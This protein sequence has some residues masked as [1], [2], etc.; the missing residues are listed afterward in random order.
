MSSLRNLAIAGIFMAGCAGPQ[1]AVRPAQRVEP[2][3]GR[4]V[5][6]ATQTCPRQRSSRI[7]ECMFEGIAQTC[8]ERSGTN[9]DAYYACVGEGLRQPVTPEPVQLSITVGQG[10]EVFSFRTGGPAIYQFAK[11]DVVA[12]DSTGVDFNFVV[13]RV[14]T[15]APTEPMVLDQTQV[16]MNFDGTRTGQWM[17]LDFTELWNFRAES[18]GDGRARVSFQTD[19]PAIVVRTSGGAQPAAEKK[20]PAPKA[21]QAPAV[22]PPAE[23][24]S[25]T[26]TSPD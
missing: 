6:L 25:T 17:H 7:Q 24:R 2:P 16:R 12:V 8:R 26:I 19:N 21:Q 20:P 5:E 13:S 14:E 10:E 18:A 15:A 4:T 9:Q 11:L 3:G 1:Q 22:Q 23:Q